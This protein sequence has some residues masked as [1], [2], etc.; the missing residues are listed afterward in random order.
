M[1]LQYFD[2]SISNNSNYIDNAQQALD[3]QTMAESAMEQMSSL[4]D[5]IRQNGIDSL[6]L[7]NSD[8]LSMIG[9]NIKTLLSNLIDSA[10]SQYNGTYI[11]SG[12]K[13]SASSLVPTPPET[14]QL[15]FELVQDTP[16]TSNPSGLRVSYK[17]N[18][19][20]RIVN[21]GSNS[22]EEVNSLSQDM[23]GGTGTEMFDGIIEL[24][25]EMMFKQDGTTRVNSAD[26]RTVSEGQ[27]IQ[28]TIKKLSDSLDKLNMETGKMGSRMNR[29]QAIQDQLKEENARTKDIKSSFE[30][31]DV[32]ESIM[33]LNK[34]N[35]ALQ[36]ALQ[37][38]S[39]LLNKSL[40]DFLG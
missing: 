3:E 17:G 24:Y 29:M 32:A 26:T 35:M 18:N 22:T 27:I 21:T 34:D 13:T 40:L 28:S 6:Q 4:L 16:T 12:T 5:Q 1:N 20:K 11:F 7:D 14:T 30:D 31:T 38:G 33:N 39:K 15:P 10:N 36:Y 25:N 23:F 19:Q 8:K 2:E 9:A 37:A